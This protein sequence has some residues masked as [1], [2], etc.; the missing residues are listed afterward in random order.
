M[1]KWSI[2]IRPNLS[3]NEIEWLSESRLGYC[4]GLSDLLGGNAAE[5]EAII[6]IEVSNSDVTQGY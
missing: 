1:P 6:R 4:R 5:I 2:W 3:F